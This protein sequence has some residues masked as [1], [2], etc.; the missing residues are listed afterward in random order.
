[1]VLISPDLYAQSNKDEAMKLS[2]HFRQ[3]GREKSASRLAGG[4]TTARGS[5]MPA[6]RHSTARKAS[7]L[8]VL[9]IAGL[10]AVIAPASSQ[11]LVT[12]FGSPLT[13]DATLNTAENLSYTGTNTPVPPSPEAP[14]GIFHTFHFGADTALW[15]AGLAGGMSGAPSGGQAIKV[16]LKGCAKPAAGGPSPL[17]QIHFQ[18]ISPLPGGGAKVNISSQ[19]FDIPVCGLGGA[20]GRT[21]TTYEPVNL[22]VSQGDYVALNENGGYVEHVYQSGVPYQILGAVNGSTG[23]SFIRHDGTGN[24]SIMLPSDNTANDGFAST[25][26]VEVMLQATLG[27]GADAAP[28][29]PGGTHGQGLAGTTAPGGAGTIK[30]QNDGMNR[31][32]I[33]SVAIYCA[34]STGCNGM[35]TLTGMASLTAVGKHISFG[36]TGFRISGKKTSHVAIHVSARLAKLVRK[37][38]GGG[39]RVTLTA[40]MSGSTVTQTIKVF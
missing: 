15:N 31:H 11:A 2:A 34:L 13:A 7:V 9:V 19:P 4:K 17:T 16:S 33:V 20:D 29:C 24:G 3:A 23:N 39:V 18:D 14:T 38:K 21:V 12:T 30:P 35:A 6:T 22:C 40:V 36:H 10:L 1:V 8:L 5:S 37:H 26:N 27:T 25:P 28:V 32:G